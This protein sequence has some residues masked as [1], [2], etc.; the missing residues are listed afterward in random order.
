MPSEIFFPKGFEWQL[1]RKHFEKYITC[2]HRNLLPNLERRAEGL[3][4]RAKDR[5]T[6]EILL[7]IDVPIKLQTRWKT[8]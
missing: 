2:S 5:V 7:K 3:R 8:K 4:A 6:E 1:G